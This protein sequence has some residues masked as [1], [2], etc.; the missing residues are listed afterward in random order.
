VCWLN[1]DKASSNGMWRDPEHSGVARVRVDLLE[2]NRS[3]FEKT[4]SK[5]SKKRI[6]DQSGA[7]P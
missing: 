6:E 4:K 1:G 3:G 7:E 5:T 2:V